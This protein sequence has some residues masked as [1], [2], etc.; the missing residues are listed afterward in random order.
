MFYEA[1]S[2]HYD[3]IFPLDQEKT[4]FLEKEFKQ[5]NAFKIL[6]LACGT[7]TYTLELAKRG[8]NVWGTDLENSMI[9]LARSKAAREQ[10]A[11][12][13]A[14]GDMRNSEELGLKFNGL[15]CIG[16]SLAHLL[17]IRDLKQALHSM[18]NVLNDGG[19]AVLQ[20]VNFDSILDTGDTQLPL[21]ERAGLRF[22]RT[23]RPRSEERL[24]FDSMLEISDGSSLKRYENSVELRPIRRLDLEQWL[25]NAGF[26]SVKI[27]G[28]F[29]Y[30]EYT[31]AAKAIVV[32]AERRG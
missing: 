21:I 29:K 6:D 31:L 9:E 32:T 8:F 22:V 7:G 1:L 24:Y 25:Y 5:K 10:V 12:N 2:E 17:D 26:S 28:D 11:V 14:V 27:Y 4:L 23:Y 13:F 19:I 18:Y 15:F 20:I 30:S 3:I 16:N